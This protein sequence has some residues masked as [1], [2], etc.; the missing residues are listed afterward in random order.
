[1]V[2]NEGAPPPP[3]PPPRV[4][5]VH[6]VSSKASRRR[7]RCIYF[8]E[9]GL[10]VWQ[11]LISCGAECGG[12]VRNGF[13]LKHTET[14]YIHRVSSRNYILCS[15]FQVPCGWFWAILFEV[16]SAQHV[17]LCCENALSILRCVCIRIKLPSFNINVR[18]VPVFN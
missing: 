17:C 4:H 13:L 18:Y 10:D 6:T 15:G 16:L 1:M 14:E 12:M 9:A 3:L 8:L 11:H 2:R 5:K 7:A